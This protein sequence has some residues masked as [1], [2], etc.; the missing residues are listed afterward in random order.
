[1]RDATVAIYR[2]DEDNKLAPQQCASATTGG[3]GKLDF[4]GV[5]VERC[6]VTATSNQAPNSGIRRSEGA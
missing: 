4:R 1:M 6:S 5:D 2:I 3:G